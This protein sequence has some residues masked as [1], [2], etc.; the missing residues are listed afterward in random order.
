MNISGYAID[1]E[2]ALTIIRKNG[3]KTIVLQIPEGLKRSIFPVV[4]VLKK[5]TNATVLVSADPCFGACDIANYEFKNLGVEFVLHI[6]HTPIPDIQNYWI[7]TKFITASSTLDVTGVVIKALASLQ[8]NKIGVLTTAQHLHT[9]ESVIDVLHTHHFTAILA[10]GDSRIS[11]QGQI[12][13]CNFSAATKMS[14]A[15]DCFLFIGSGTFHPIGLLLSSKKPVIAAD[16]Y[17]NSI[18]THELEEIKNTILRQRYAAIIAAQNAHRFGILIGVKQ[19]QQRLPLAY[20]LQ[21]MLTSAGKQFLLI[22]QDEF[23]PMALQ[24]FDLDCYV[25]TACPRI[26]I[27]DYLQYKKP[28]ITPVELEIALG[29]RTWD[30]YVFDEIL[31]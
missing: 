6:G 30:E 9:L 21:Q 23:S 3:Y 17:T 11:Y 19:G 15:V 28:I 5:K 18:K 10:K 14:D 8:G 16:P 1:I 13:G 4:D 25:S 2:P 12:L 26:A 24:G 7:P 31:S 29:K 20:K 27:D 22:T